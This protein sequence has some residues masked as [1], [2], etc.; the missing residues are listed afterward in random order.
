MAF[1]PETPQIQ[2][3][4]VKKDSKVAKIYIT[5]ALSPKQL[6]KNSPQ[7]GVERAKFDF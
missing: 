6:G 2:P 3:I 5:S 1:C 7:K 4:P